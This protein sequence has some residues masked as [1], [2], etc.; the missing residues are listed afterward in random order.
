MSKDTIEKVKGQ[1][2][3]WE[4]VFKNHISD[5]DL[6]SRIKKELLQSKIKRQPNLKMGKG[7]VET[8]LQRHASIQK[9]R[10][11]H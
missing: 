2:T 4:K 9:N 11:S 5:K 10:K 8:F 7:S 1:P 6:V 3:Q